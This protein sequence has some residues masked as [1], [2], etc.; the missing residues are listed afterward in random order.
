MKWY[1]YRSILFNLNKTYIFFRWFFIILT[2]ILPMAFIDFGNDNFSISFMFGMYYPYKYNYLIQ[3]LD[4]VLWYIMEYPMIYVQTYIY[5]IFLSQTYY[6]EKIN[7]NSGLY[8]FIIYM[9]II[10]IIVGGIVLFN[11]KEFFTLGFLTVIT[12]SFSLSLMFYWYYII[13]DI[14]INFIK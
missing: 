7:K 3:S 5:V 13:R 14:I 8:H 9:R 10:L 2:P 11:L 1:L 6:W 4:C 12:S